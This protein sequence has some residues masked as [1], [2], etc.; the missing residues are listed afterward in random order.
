MR[1]VIYM[2]IAIGFEVFGSTMLKLSEGFTKLWPSLGVFL[3][4][5]VAFTMLSLALRYIP[6]SLAYSTWS[7]V[8][9]A[10]TALI[11]IILFQESFGIVKLLGLFLVI[12]GIVLLNA[13]Q[14]APAAQEVNRE[15]A[16]S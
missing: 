9:T 12:V 13:R 10:L 5:G 2:S 14:P 4:F 6:L 15:K 7:G 16:A 3:G 1:A 11:G 8:G